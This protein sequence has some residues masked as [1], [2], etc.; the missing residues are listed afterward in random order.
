MEMNINRNLHQNKNEILHYLRDRAAESYGEIITIHGERDYKQRAGAINKAIVNT[1]QNLRT[2]I[3]QRSLSQS[4]G[5]EEE[6]NNHYLQTLKN[7]GIWDV[8]CGSETY[9]QINQY[10]GFD[11]ASWIENNIQWEEDLD[12]DTQSHFQSNDLV[13]YLSW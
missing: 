2:I 4:W 3:I 1:A 7:S 12:R 13:K 10:S 8:Y 6:Q 9:E 5:K 11:L